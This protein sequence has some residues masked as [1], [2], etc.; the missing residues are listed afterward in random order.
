MATKLVLAGIALLASSSAWAQAGAPQEQTSQDIVCQLSDT[1]EAAV[2]QE[3][4]TEPTPVGPGAPRVSGATRGFK[5]ALPAEPAAPRARSGAE[6]RTR[7]ATDTNKQTTTRPGK[8]RKPMTAVK[9]AASGRADLRLSFVT[10]SAELTE[11][12]QREAMKFVDALS[13]PLLKGMRFSIEGH[14]DAAGS[15]ESNLDLSKRRAEAVVDYLAG[16]GAD[17]SRFEVKGYGFDR[18]LPG[19]PAGAAANRRVEVVRIK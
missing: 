4:D 15:R 10:G 8:A 13:S 2:E 6:K 14:T 19:L 5:I 16:K 1:C 11:A 18:P 12:G 17:R 9:N 7:V 3:A